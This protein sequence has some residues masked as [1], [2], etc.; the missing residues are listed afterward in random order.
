[1]STRT[2]PATRNAFTLVELLVVIGIIAV[3][4]AILLPS[5]TKARAHAQAVA[6][7]SNLRQIGL[8]FLMYANDNDLYLPPLQE[9]L[10]SNPVPRAGAGMHWFEFLGEGKYTPE[11]WVG[12][13]MT[14]RGYFTGIWRCP[15]VTDD[16]VLAITGSFGWGGGYGVCGNGTSMPFRYWNYGTTTPPKRIGGP[17]LNRVDRHTDRFLVGDTG[18]PAGFAGNW[19][20]WHQTFL[21]PFNQSGNGSNTNQPACRHSK[22]ANVC[23]YDG[24]VEGV[25]FDELNVTPLANN[26]FFPTTA[27][28][29]NY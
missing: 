10:V 20:T 13:P 27:E 7:Q 17:K 21:P 18:R 22:R 29:N 28:A 26:R 19:L 11:G 24:H 3:L 14:S 25:L 12:D 8:G 2:A 6:C 15:S 16:Q 4:I 1:M 5:L 23:F 9:N